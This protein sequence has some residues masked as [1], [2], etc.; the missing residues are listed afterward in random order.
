[1]NYSVSLEDRVGQGYVFSVKK[2]P[3]SFCEYLRFWNL[4]SVSYVVLPYGE[5]AVCI[6]KKREKKVWLV[7]EVSLDDDLFGESWENRK[8]VYFCSELVKG[9][10]VNARRFSAPELFQRL[11]IAAQSQI[12]DDSIKKEI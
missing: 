9:E 3:E 7:E 10:K 4:F 6:Q 1:M 8:R 12:Y 11:Y 5:D 2:S